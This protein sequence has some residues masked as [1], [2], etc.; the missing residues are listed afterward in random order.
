MVGIFKQICLRRFRLQN[1]KRLLL[2]GRRCPE[3]RADHSVGLKI[4][5]MR[6]NGTLELNLEDRILPEKNSL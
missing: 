5:R 6:F 3:S 1:R 4:P 2:F